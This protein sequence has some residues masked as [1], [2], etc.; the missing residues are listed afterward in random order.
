MNFEFSPEEQDFQK[1]VQ[2]FFADDP[3][4]PGMAAEIEKG[5]G[6]GPHTWAIL[7]K[8]GARGWLTPTW[9]KEYGGLELNEMHKYLVMDAMDYYTDRGTLV[10]AGM[11]GPV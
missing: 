2:S 4:T 1:Q 11:A 9:P 7:R 8:L 5:E 10:A 3:D 6:F